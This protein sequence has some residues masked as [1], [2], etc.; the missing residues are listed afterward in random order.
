[1]YLDLRDG[2]RLVAR[3]H[4]DHRLHTGEDIAVGIDPGR[5]YLFQ[6]DGRALAYR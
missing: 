1:V 5:L 3:L 4:A 2:T 6:A